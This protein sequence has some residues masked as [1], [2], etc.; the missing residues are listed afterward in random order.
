MLDA[1][2]RHSFDELQHRQYVTARPKIALRGDTG[3][4]PVD[5]ELSGKGQHRPWTLVPVPSVAVARGPWSRAV[6]QVDGKV[7]QP[8]PVF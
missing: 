8:S 7:R 3:E 1:V 6:A 2:V 5:P 4:R